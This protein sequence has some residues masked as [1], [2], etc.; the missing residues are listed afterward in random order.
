MIRPL[1]AIPSKGRLQDQTIE[2]LASIG[3]PLR[4]PAQERGYTASLEGIDIDV[5][6]ISAREIAQGLQ[7]GEFHA[8]LTG[9]DLLIETG[10]QAHNARSVLPLGFGRADL[11]VAVPSAWLD[12]TT[13]ADLDDIAEALVRQKGRP[14]R[15]ATKYHR[16][17]REFFRMH[18]ITAYRIFDSQGATEGAPA[19]G[20]ADVIVDITSSGAT[21]AANHLRP[22]EDGVIVRSEAEFAISP[23]ANWCAPH[24]AAIRS[25]VERTEA[26][27]LARLSTVI[28]VSAPLEEAMIRRFG[29]QTLSAG[30]YRVENVHR[31]AL[32]EALQAEGA[33]L[34]AMTKPDFLF[35]ATGK[36]LAEFDT[37]AREILQ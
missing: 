27:D 11:V 1:L 13:M 9:T 19:A 6:L 14:L 37:F 8:G 28:E 31:F 35:G 22:L 29:L 2:W 33:P 25:L 18:A 4:R 21:L 20:L 3:T 34:I 5:Q 12:A 24:L 15:V 32:I 17:T 26:R 10:G 7:R 36:R 16:A 30:R 23:A